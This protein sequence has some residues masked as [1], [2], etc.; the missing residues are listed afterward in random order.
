MSQREFEFVSDKSHKF[1]KIELEGNSHTVH[2]GR[3]GMAG[4]TK[5]KQFANEDETRASYEKLISQKLKKGYVEIGGQPAPVADKPAPIA[6]IQPDEQNR[7]S[8]E[9]LIAADPDN[10]Q[11][12]AAFADWLTGQGDPRGEF[13]HVQLQLED[14][15]C[16]PEERK[17]LKAREEEMLD[18]H[19]RE[20]LGGLADFLELTSPAGGSFARGYLDGL[21]IGSLNVAFAR[22]LAK[23]PET[24]LLRRLEI[25]ACA[26]GDDDEYEP[27]DDIPEIDDYDQP[28]LYP[29]LGSPYL[30]NVEVLTIGEPASLDG[31]Y[32]TCWM[33]GNCA[34]DLVAKMPRLEELYL[35]CH[36]ADTH[37][38]FGLKTLT[39]LRVMHLFHGKSFP[40][41]QLAANEAFS[42]LTH[43]AIHPHAV[44]P[45]DTP[46]LGLEGLK[47][48]VES[49]HLGKL[50]HL[51]FRLSESGDAGCEA[52]VN[53]GILRQLKVLDLRSGKITDRGAGVLAACPD[54]KNLEL[55]ELR[56]NALTRDGIKALRATGLT[57]QAKDQNAAGEAEDSVD[58]MYDGDWE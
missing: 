42:N 21:V 38:L 56:N 55:L 26:Y 25:N 29:L 33:D 45:D 14:E 52:V 20:W 43:L 24:W 23:A 8:F 36:N 51:H 15:S 3:V 13:I 39:N 27:G 7:E 22:A 34:A 35:F 46:Y 48:I 49:P 30:G 12:R 6:D 5:T 4:Q 37:K 32:N 28:G 54:L 11:N 16:T 40:L 2:F 44:E 53:S 47:A 17:T 10:L 1:W 31:Q 9:K 50:T 18:A 58:W 19:S 57:V 41:S